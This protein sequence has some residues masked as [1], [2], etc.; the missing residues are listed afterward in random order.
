MHHEQETKQTTNIKKKNHLSARNILDPTVHGLNISKQQFSSPEASLIWC[1]HE[2]VTTFHSNHPLHPA[3]CPF[4]DSPHYV[5]CSP[6]VKGVF[7]SSN[8]IHTALGFL[9]KIE[10]NSSKGIIY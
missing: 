1:E 3:L 7:L 9:K 6:S 8:L 4:S 2:A 5:N 10:N